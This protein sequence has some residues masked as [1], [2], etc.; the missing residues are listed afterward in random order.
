MKE[1]YSKYKAKQKKL[2]KL[3]KKMIQ[4]GLF[5]FFIVLD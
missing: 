2:K 1:F 3:I 5:S 4:N